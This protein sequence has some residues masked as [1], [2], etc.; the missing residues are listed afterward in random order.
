MDAG[1]L[2]Q[3]YFCQ[4]QNFQMVSSEIKT[5]VCFYHVNS[6]PFLNSITSAG[7]T[8]AKCKCV[9]HSPK[10]PNSPKILEKKDFLVN[11]LLYFPYPHWTSFSLDLFLI[12]LYIYVYRINVYRVQVYSYYR[13]LYVVEVRQERTEKGGFPWTVN[14]Q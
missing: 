10:T 8:T 2:T 4:F 3:Q 11:Y 13:S 14:Y 1:Q 9:S 6:F 5:L 7:K 12:Y